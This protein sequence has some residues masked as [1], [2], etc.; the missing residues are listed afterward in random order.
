M[1]GPDSGG[2]GLLTFGLVK[3]GGAVWK[4]SSHAKMS[5]AVKELEKETAEAAAKSATNATGES[6][7][8]A[9]STN[10]RYSAS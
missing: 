4:Q 7:A 8:A 9:G 1:H 5:T 2:I 3:G 10:D 6:A